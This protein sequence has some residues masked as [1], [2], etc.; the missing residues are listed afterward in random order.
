MNKLAQ[1][2]K[3]TELVG[4]ATLA[5]EEVVTSSSGSQQKIDA[6]G[7]RSLALDALERFANSAEDVGVSDRALA[8][9]SALAKVV[10]NSSISDIL[11][12]ANVWNGF[13]A[14]FNRADQAEKVEILT[15]QWASIAATTAQNVDAMVQQASAAATTLKDQLA[16]LK[17]ELS[18]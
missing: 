14:A 1:L 16:A 10:S 7:E 2:L 17:D 15:E 9:H 13:E 11:S 18:S 12:T 5:H 4:N 3:L 6:I 8:A